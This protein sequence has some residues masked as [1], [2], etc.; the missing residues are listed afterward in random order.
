[1]SQ[2]NRQLLLSKK[3]MPV[4][5]R[6]SLSGTY[7]LPATALTFG[8]TLTKL[9]YWSLKLTNP[10]LLIAEDHTLVLGGYLRLL[11][12]QFDIVGTAEDGLTLVT[13]ALALK[14]DAILVDISLPKLNGFE[15]ARRIR[16]SLPDVK[17]IFVTIHSGHEYVT[18]ALRLGAS[19]Y[20]L[21]RSAASEL[22]EAIRLVL[23][24]EVFLS[25]A[26]SEPSPE[27]EPAV[28]PA[29]F[30]AAL[31]IRERH[32]LQLVAEGRAGKEIA[33]DLDISLK[34]VEFHKHR[35]MQKL[36]AKSTA[37]LTRYAIRHGVIEP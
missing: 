19:G 18:E 22:A 14:P 36:G 5:G 25:P 13:K 3:E 31:T 17:L 35:I 2:D 12:G 33:D 7:T 1:M 11:E 24:G 26:L 27:E 4:G 16:T 34:T 30:G 9:V 23:S 15:A 37:E 10:R 28:D 21:K 6:V 32:V 29:R 8:Y 20:V